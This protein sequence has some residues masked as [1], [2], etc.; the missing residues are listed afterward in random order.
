MEMMTQTKPVLLVTGGAR[1]IGAQVVQGA[2]ARGYTVAFSYARND[3]AA[4]RLEEEIARETGRE[5]GRAFGI[6]SDVREPSAVA[7]LFAQVEQELGPIDALVNNAGVTGPLGRFT[8]ASVETLQDVLAVNVLGTMLCAQE[9][10]RRWEQRGVAGAMVNISS[11]AAALGGPNEYVHYA[12]SKAAVEAF[13]VG[14]A[15]E[16]AASGARVN[17]VAPGTTLT[18]IHAAA[19]DPGRPARVA[20]RIP[21]GRVAEPQEIAEAVLWLLSP[22]ASYVTGTVLRVAGGL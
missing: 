5:G 15:R 8:N 10:I 4:R 21:L 11:I 2:V 7:A 14:L 12:A 16:V 3:D 20:S 13:T 6:R 1:G 17:A 18:E 9:A 22:Q 19:G